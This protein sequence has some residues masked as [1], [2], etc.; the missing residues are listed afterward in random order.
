M[1]GL[2]PAVVAAATLIA[3]SDG[4]H[5]VR[6]CLVVVTTIS[7]RLD[8]GGVGRI[9]EVDPSVVVGPGLARTN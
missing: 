7:V 8:V 5:G 4:H 3:A 9:Q 2:Q 1:A 6:S